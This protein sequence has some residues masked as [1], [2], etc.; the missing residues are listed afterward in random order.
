MRWSLLLLALLALA[1]CS[2]SAD[3][4]GPSTSAATSDTPAERSASNPAVADSASRRAL[5]TTA[6][7]TMAHANPTLQLVGRTVA[8]CESQLA[9]RVFVNDSAALEPAMS[10]AVTRVLAGRVRLRLPALLE[11]GARCPISK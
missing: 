11:F 3:P 9:P 5:D 10:P 8:R 7:A 6:H 1:G 4:L 2:E